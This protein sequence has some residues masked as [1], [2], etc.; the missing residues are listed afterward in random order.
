MSVPAGNAPCQ[1][2]VS[3]FAMK[4]WFATP[5][6]VCTTGKVPVGAVW[7]NLAL[8]TPFALSAWSVVW[9]WKKYVPAAA[10]LAGGIKGTVE[11]ASA[12]EAPSTSRKRMGPPLPIG[13]P[14][15]AITGG[16]T[17]AGYVLV[18]VYAR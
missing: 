4:S 15:S 6:V 1:Y 14:R 11:R 9:P 17:A 12:S 10:A 16:R 5:V 3:G 18:T 7:S 13:R 2:A 8:A